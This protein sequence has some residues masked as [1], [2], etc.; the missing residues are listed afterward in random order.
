MLDE[1]QTFGRSGAPFCAQHFLNEPD[2][3]TIAKG[4]VV[5]VTLARSEFQSV[6]HSGWHSNTWGGGKIFDNEL[7]WATLDALKNHREPA[8]DGA[9]YFENTRVKGAYLALLLDRVK[10]RHPDLL[11]EHS[12]IGLLHGVTLKRREEVIEEAWRKGLKLLGCGLP[13]EAA[14]ARV[15]FLVDAT[16]REI[17]DFAQTF[18]R[19]LE[20]VT[21]KAARA[22]GGSVAAAARAVA[23]AGLLAGAP[24]AAG[25]CTDANPITSVQTQIEARPQ[26]QAIVNTQAAK[27]AVQ[28]Y[29]AKHGENP[30]SIEA[31]EA[32]EGK[33]K[34]PPAGWRYVYNPETGVIDLVDERPKR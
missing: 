11:V 23:V 16:A 34:R 9:S 29:Q 7:A 12:G 1:V 27:R 8:F 30:P 15:L 2:I 6:L 3:L 21:A 4:A 19:V 10:E 31:L 25:G 28:A 13:G 5:G 24:A 22:S 17:E 33:L 26:A 32:S 18:D 20:A 14:R